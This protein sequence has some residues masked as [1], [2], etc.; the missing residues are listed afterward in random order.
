[1][2]NR[3][4]TKR[5]RKKG[6]SLAVCLGVVLL[7]VSVLFNGYTVAKYLAEKREAKLYT[8]MDFYFTSDYLKPVQSNG[9]YAL[10]TLR[11]G[12]D[13]IDFELRNYDDALRSSEVDISYEVYL[14]GEKKAQ[15]SIPTASDGSESVSLADLPAGEYTVIAKAVGPYTKTI[16]A[17]FRVVSQTPAIEATAYGSA[18][19]PMMQLTVKTNDYSGNVVISWGSGVMPDKTDPKLANVS[20]SAGSCVVYMANDSEYTFTFYKSDLSADLTGTLSAA[21]ANG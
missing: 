17:R 15:G 2:R 19:H 9:E 20:A 5:R 1:M 7:A 16:G 10:Y 14:D 3:A 4:Y 13:T 11:E 12:V 21:I 6:L 18:S 8:A